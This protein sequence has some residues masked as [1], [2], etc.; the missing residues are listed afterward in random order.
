LLI[1]QAGDATGLY[2]A[3]QP[4][5]E[6]GNNR[7]TPWRSPR[8]VSVGGHP[9]SRG[10]LLAPWLPWRRSEH[11]YLF[12]VLWAKYKSTAAVS[13]R[14]CNLVVPD[15]PTNHLVGELDALSLEFNK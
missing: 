15:G 8:R 11:P 4:V 5:K 12:H 13:P 3:A 9:Q 2:F 6:I 7:N 14:P 1:L 10:F